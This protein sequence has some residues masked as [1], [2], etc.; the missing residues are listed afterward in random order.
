MLL[1]R[2]IQI[3]GNFKWKKQKNRKPYKK[4]IKTENLQD[5]ALAGIQTVDYNNDTSLDDLETVDYNNDTLVTDLVPI[6]KLKTIKE[7]ENDDI[8]VIKMTQTF[9]EEVFTNIT[10]KN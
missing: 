10:K 9:R 6:R 8:E 4:L 3:N 7:D 1:K 5:V 2:D